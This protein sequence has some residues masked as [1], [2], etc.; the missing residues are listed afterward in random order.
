[1]NQL[2]AEVLNKK[3]AK[4]IK[5]CEENI[6]F[7]SSEN[8]YAQAIQRSLNR[9]KK[10]LNDIQFRDPSTLRHDLKNPLAAA[11]GFAELLK[12]KAKNE[13]KPHAENIYKSLCNILEK[14][15][16]AH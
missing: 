2:L 8:K 12:L 4:D 9:I 16:N 10:I 3:I 7:F 11:L 6:E 15:N 14:I 5:N 13:E 1:M